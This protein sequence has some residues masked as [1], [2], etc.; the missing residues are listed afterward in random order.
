MEK[1]KVVK[2]R[3]GWFRDSWDAEKKVR[4][5]IEAYPSKDSIGTFYS[6]AFLSDHDYLMHKFGFYSMQEAFEWADSQVDY[7]HNRFKL[8]YVKMLT[9]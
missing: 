8:D 6:S 2:G 7:A 5:L 4:C 3:K 9:K 1:E